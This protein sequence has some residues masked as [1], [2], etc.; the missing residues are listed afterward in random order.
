MTECKGH[1]SLAQGRSSEAL[2]DAAKW[3]LDTALEDE[4]RAFETYSAILDRYEDAR[5]FVNIVEAEARHIN[6]LLAVYDHYG[7]TPPVDETLPDPEALRA[8]LSELCAIGVAAEI[9]NVDLYDQKLLPAVEAY[10]D[11]TN[12]FRRLR[13]ASEFRHLRAFQRCVDRNARGR[14]SFGNGQRRRRQRRGNHNQEHSC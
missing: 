11:I 3:A 9:E 8:P 14:G 2:A 6:A 13:D 10:T 5:P 12:V 1:C 4:R 7:L